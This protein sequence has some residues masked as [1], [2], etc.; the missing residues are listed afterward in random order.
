MNAPRI[1]A[2]S[3]VVVGLAIALGITLR[4]VWPEDIEYKGDER[5]IF[6]RT[7]TA[8]AGGPW[9]WIGQ[10]TSMLLPHPGM[11]VWI[12]ILLGWVLDARTAPQLALGVQLLNAV[13]ILGW[14]AFARFAL[15]QGVRRTWYWAAALWAVNPVAVILERKIWQPSITPIFVIA[16]IA[17]WWH[18]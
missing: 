5:W 8:L 14:M 3:S 6:E 13:A 18:R 16:F 15:P 9:P 7:Q 10:L 11:S 2:R 12:F 4:L 17:A 1:L